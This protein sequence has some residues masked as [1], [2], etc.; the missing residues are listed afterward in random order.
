MNG[1]GL[2]MSSDPPGGVF[3]ASRRRPHQSDAARAAIW[4]PGS[5]ILQAALELGSLDGVGTQ[6]DRHLVGT[7]SGRSLT[8][9]LEQ[10]GMR[11][12]QRLVAL[13]RGVVQQRAEQVEGC[14]RATPR[15]RRRQRG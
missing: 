12:M 7:H 4:T 14:L 9:A 11:G 1:L 3:A 15:S 5:E 6:L 13:E 8:G 2:Q 10:L